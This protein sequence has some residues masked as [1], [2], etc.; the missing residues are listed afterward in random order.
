MHSKALLPIAALCI[1]VASGFWLDADSER[2]RSHGATAVAK[3]NNQLL[4]SI[5]ETLGRASFQ[6]TFASGGDCRDVSTLL[7]EL[8]ATIDESIQSIAAQ[9]PAAPGKVAQLAE[10]TTSTTEQKALYR[11]VEQRIYAYA[12]SG[13]PLLQAMGN[14]QDFQRLSASQKKRLAREVAQRFNQGEISLAQLRGL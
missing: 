7:P 1:G 6:Q 13:E 12:S 10:T 14:D 9:H 3:Q 4:H 2:P 11:S 5:E 8:K